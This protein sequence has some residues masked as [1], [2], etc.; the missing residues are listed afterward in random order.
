MQK[1]SLGISGG[2]DK[3]TFYFSADYLNQKGIA[4]GSGFQ[5]AS[6]RFNLTNQATKWLKFSTNLSFFGT[7]ENVNVFQGQ[8]V[9]QALTQNPTIPGLRN[10]MTFWR[11]VRSA[12][13]STVLRIR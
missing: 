2:T 4:I 13:C 8:I 12:W 3:T 9:N 5:R 11:P 6:T 1:H 10:P 7:K